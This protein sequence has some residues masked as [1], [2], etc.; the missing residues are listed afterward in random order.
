MSYKSRSNYAIS[1]KIDQKP[2]P[3]FPTDKGLRLVN[4]KNLNKGE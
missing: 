2:N 1:Q 3:A 4:T